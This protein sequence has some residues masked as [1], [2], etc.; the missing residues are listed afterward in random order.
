MPTGPPVPTLEQNRRSI[1]AELF[2]IGDMRPG[3]LVH[4][5]MKCSTPTCRCWQ[6]GDPGHGPDFLLV[7]NLD[8]KRTSRSLPSAAATTVQSQLDEYQRFR[9]LTAELVDVCEQLA[10]ARLPQVGTDT[11]NEAKKSVHAGVRPRHRSRT[12]PLRSSR[13][14]GRRRFRGAGDPPAPAGA[15]TGSASRGMALQRRPQRSRRPGPSLSLR[16]AGALRRTARPICP[17]A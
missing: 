12:R 17:R 6:E 15:G 1:L 14:G 7:R 5:Y 8:G 13:R 16:P 10:D 2:A 3:S 11:R 4:R 9:R